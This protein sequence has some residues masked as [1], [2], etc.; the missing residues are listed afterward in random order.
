MNI[1]VVGTGYVGLV[2]GAC[3][4]EKGNDVWCVDVDE[5]RIRKLKENKIPIY[6]PGLD[7]L[8]AKNNLDGRLHFSMDIRDGLDSADIC[9]FA[10]GT[11]QNGDG[12]S[13]LRQVIAAADQV[14]DCVKC[15]CFV[16]LKSTVPVG[17]NRLVRERLSSRL[18]ERG[19]DYRIDVISNPEFL[20][21]GAAVDDCLNPDRIVVGAATDAAGEIMRELYGPFGEDRIVFMDP[22]S[23][24]ITKYTA[25]AMLAARISLM[26][27]ISRLCDAAGAD[28]C[29]VKD[30]ISRDRRIGPHFLNAGCGY[31]G[32]CFP[33]DVRALAKTGLEYGLEMK[34]IKAIDEVNEEQKKI[35]PAMIKRRFG[36]DMAG[37]KIAVLG[38]AF[39]PKT[40]DMREA[41]SI[42][43]IKDLLECGASV[44]VFDPVAMRHANKILPPGVAYAES[45]TDAI[46][47][48]DAVALVT[49]WPEFMSLDWNDLGELMNERVIFD[50]R[51]IFNPQEMVEGGFEYY[52]IGKGCSYLGKYPYG[53][54]FFHNIHSL[55]DG[56]V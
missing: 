53:E 16:V 17:T 44:V 43:L 51:N 33:K 3:L 2:T 25:N 13:D 9:F 45:I 52:C 35:L 23:A 10:V 34:M 5:D 7:E 27:E 18:R 56:R 15:D 8:V 36:E 37:V 46:A 24:E 14:A 41:P 6:E 30:G 55:V 39:K 29:S 50:G 19:V 22:A 31:G 47:E 11:P 54:V 40:N 4:A 12:S 48:A 26:N 21:E 20:K 49:E 42:T 28:I 38:L 1:C 32:S